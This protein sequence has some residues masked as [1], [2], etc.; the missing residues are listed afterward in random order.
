MMR[1][2]YT[3]ATGMQA[4]QVN[5]DNISNNLANV[6]TTAFKQTRV[7]FQDLLYAQSQDPGTEATAG[8]Q[9]GMGVRAASTQRI[10]NQGSIAN[11]GVKSD[12]AIQGDGFFQVTTPNGETAY[13]RDG[14]FKLDKDGGLVT[15]SG[16]KTGVTIPKDIT[17][18][19]IKPNG[20]VWAQALNDTA[21]KKIGQF[22]L[23]RFLNPA[24]LQAIGGNLYKSTSVCGASSMGIPGEN[25]MGV[26]AQGHLEKSNINVVVEMMNIVQA[27]RAYE[28]AQKGV[29]AADEMT[30]M[31][32]QM[33]K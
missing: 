4:Q 7:D 17:D 22:K 10:F 19:E 25:G 26:L 20:E 31:A 6:Q 12:V 2:L 24:G 32:S 23:T 8:T 3:A 27:Q 14:S 30:R 11:T 5:I 28:M 13:T 18:Y 16:Y 33:Q 21:P 1:G 9:T 15:Q 29:Q